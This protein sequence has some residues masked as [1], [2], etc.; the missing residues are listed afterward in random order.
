MHNPHYA[1]FGRTKTLTK[2]RF[3]SDSKAADI[4]YFLNVFTGPVRVKTTNKV[5]VFAAEGG[6]SNTSAAKILE[7]N[8]QAARFYGLASLIAIPVK[9][10]LKILSVCAYRVYPRPVPLRFTEAHLRVETTKV[11]ER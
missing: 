6:Y 3:A 4:G 8:F 5:V 7:V 10:L 9:L 11:V 1:T 2:H